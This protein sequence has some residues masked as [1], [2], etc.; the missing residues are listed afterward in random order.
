MTFGEYITKKR[1]EKKITLRGF[2]RMLDIS[3][4]YVCNFEKNRKPAPKA[5]L[6][7]K[8]V[9]GFLLNDISYFLDRFNYK[10]SL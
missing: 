9:A 10:F 1:L 3:P 2:A 8:I 6:L 4:E 7:K 5:D